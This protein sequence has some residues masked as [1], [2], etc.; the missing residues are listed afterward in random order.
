MRPFQRL[1]IN[2]NQ[3]TIKT[4]NLTARSINL[5]FI[6]QRGVFMLK[7]FL[8]TFTL[9]LGLSG[10]THYSGG[11]AASTTPLT[12]GSYQTLGEV[13]GNDCVYSLLGMIPLSSGNE[14]RK[15]IEDAISQKEGATALIEVTSDTYSQFYL[16]YGRTCTQVYGTA[17]APR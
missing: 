11:I 14:T 8:V 5:F 13:E 12:M 6:F 15:A 1:A 3:L 17:V 10:C 7:K 9:L 16:L 2:K 4:E